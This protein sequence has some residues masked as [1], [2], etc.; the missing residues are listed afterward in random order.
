[1]GGCGSHS[2][3]D[4][5]ALKLSWLLLRK[6]HLKVKFDLVELALDCKNSG[7]DNN[8]ALWSK[9]SALTTVFPTRLVI[10][11]MFKNVFS[12]QEL[13]LRVILVGTKKR[14]IK[15]CFS[16]IDCNCYLLSFFKQSMFMI[17]CNENKFYLIYLE[18]KSNKKIKFVQKNLGNFKIWDQYLELKTIFHWL[19]S[20]KLHSNEFSSLKIFRSGLF[21]NSS[22]FATKWADPR[23]I[24]FF[25]QYKLR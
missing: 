2:C 8:W 4:K 16:H 14:Y 20:V 13:A 3:D 9:L 5:I 10:Y 19:T 1:M 17:N 7:I 15:P 18:R 22:S 23:L 11:F 6:C 25:L 12:I 21:F 24:W